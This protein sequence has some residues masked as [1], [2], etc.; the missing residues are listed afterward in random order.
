LLWQDLREYIK[1]LDEMGELKHISEAGWEEEIGGITELMV[2]RNGPALLFDDIPGYP[3][4]FRVGTNLLNTVR[5]TAVALGLPTEP[6]LDDVQDLWRDKM[7]DVK[8]VP[9]EEVATGPVMENVLEGDAIDLYKFPTPTWHESDGGRYIGTGVCIIQRD[10]DTGNVNVGQYRVAVYNKNTCTIFIEHGKDGDRIRRKHWSRGEKCPIVISVGQD[11]V[12]TILGGPTIHRT[13]AVMSEFEVAGYLM[14][15]PYQ[16]VKGKATGLP[17]PAHAEIVIEGFMPSPDEA[18]DPEGPFGEWTGYYAHGR[19]PETIV[20]VSTIYHRNNPIIFG[21]PPI[22]PVGCAFAGNLGGDDY[23]A[24][25]ELERA[26]IPGV[27]RVHTLANPSLRVVSMKQMYKG[28]VDDVVKV[29]E[30]GGDQYNG[31]HIWII[32]DDDI[33]PTNEKEVMWAI[34]SRCAPEIG[35]K[36]IPGTAVWQLDPRIP[37]EGRSDP[38][39]EHGRHPYTADNLVLNCTRPFEWMNDFPPVAVNGPELRARILDRWK[40]LF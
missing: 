23:P 15:A 2:E 13:P 36:V 24:M 26:K 7:R 40:E 19:R 34:A 20:E 12:L 30:P 4:G 32:V 6:S 1:K 35:V 28:H 21:I 18:L 3:S 25:R 5:R 29:L 22:R 27:L 39:T 10:P 38:N 31:H 14:G 16:V 33:D 37:P 11:P 17:I 9:A 8:P